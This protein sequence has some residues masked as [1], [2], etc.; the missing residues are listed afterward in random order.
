MTTAMTMT[1]PIISHRLYELIWKFMQQQ[2]RESSRKEG[3]RGIK[4]VGKTKPQNTYT[5]THE[6]GDLL[7][8]A[9]M[10]NVPH[11]LVTL[12]AHRPL[13]PCFIL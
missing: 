3:W 4:R 7:L 8:S 1:T 9:A 6:V 12:S 11:F 10:E 13:P 2:G 5:N